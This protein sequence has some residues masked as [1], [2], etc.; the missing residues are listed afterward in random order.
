MCVCVHV[1]LSVRVAVNNCTVRHFNLNFSSRG[2]HS[3][4]ESRSLSRSF[5]RLRFYVCLETNSYTFDFRLLQAAF[6][7]QIPSQ[8]KLTSRFY[9]TLWSGFIRVHDS[10]HSQSKRSIHA[11][12][13]VGLLLLSSWQMSRVCQ[14]NFKLHQ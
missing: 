9:S 11:E 14:E 10:L 2:L 5:F 6:L 4:P 12:F 13:L 7:Q 3:Q 8:A 1:M